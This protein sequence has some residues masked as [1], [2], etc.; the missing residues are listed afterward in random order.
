MDALKV[1]NLSYAYEENKPVIKNI[2]FN[3]EVGEYISIIGH[4]GSGKST[5]AQLIVGL[6]ETKNSEITIFDTP[7]TKD[8]VNQVR[9]DVGIVFQNPDNQFVGSTVEDDIAFG[10]E[11]HSVPY[12]EMHS[13]VEEYASKVGMSDYLNTEPSS[14]SG[15]QKQRVALAGVLA[16]N[17]KLLILDEATSMLDPR[18]KKEILA[19]I[20]DLKK[21]NPNLTIISI[22]HDIEEAYLSDRVFVLDHGELAL[23]GTPDE[24]FSDEAKIKEL[25]LE[26]P[27]IYKFKNELLKYGYDYSDVKSIDEAI[28]KLCQ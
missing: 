11:N 25:K 1:E 4:N 22:T 10:L 9:Q 7:L 8:T 18:G 3:V 19:L 28:D 6:F 16:M 14:L 13:L 23:M 15:G 20:R 26:Q 21:Q 2:S 24:V 12:Q 17:P 27:F 5:L